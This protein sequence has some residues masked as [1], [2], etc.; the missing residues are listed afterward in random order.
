MLDN[1]R[2]LLRRLDPFLRELTPIVDYLGLYKREIA[3]FFGNDSRG[4]AGHR[5]GLRELRS[6]S[7]T[8]A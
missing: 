5:A 2:P 7:T 4:H 1:T 3:A 8:C 6:R